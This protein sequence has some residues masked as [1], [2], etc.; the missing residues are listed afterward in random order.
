M[1]QAYYRAI[2]VDNDSH[3][4]A[5]RQFGI[6]LTQK[7]Y[8]ETLR[9][10]AIKHPPEYVGLTLG[11]LPS[12]LHF[13][14]TNQVSVDTR[15]GQF[16][17]ATRKMNLAKKK[18]ESQFKTK[19]GKVKKRLGGPEWA[20]LSDTLGPT[21]LL[22]CLSASHR[23]YALVAL[24]VHVMFSHRERTSLTKDPPIARQRHMWIR[25]RPRMPRMRSR[26]TWGECGTAIWRGSSPEAPLAYSGRSTSGLIRRAPLSSG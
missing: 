19:Q 10:F 5:I 21:T 20:R 1:L 2:G 18:E 25:E 4:G 7:K 9:F 3:S 26:R 24:L 6:D 14:A 11:D 8:P 12:P 23:L 16:L 15:I 17:G 22:S 13:D